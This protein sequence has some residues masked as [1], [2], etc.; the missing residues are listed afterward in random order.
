MRVDKKAE[1][2][3]IKFV[4]IDQPGKATVRGAPDD[5]VAQVIDDCCAQ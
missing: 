2:G 3:E 5:L 4:L 1:A